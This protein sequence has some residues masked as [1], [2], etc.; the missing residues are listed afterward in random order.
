MS[1]IYRK[2]EKAGIGKLVGVRLTL[3]PVTA[4]V[5]K[6]EDARS[7]ESSGGKSKVGRD[8]ATRG[9]DI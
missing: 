1:G 9:G 2:G 8:G 7:W 3:P 5:V 6:Q 4:S